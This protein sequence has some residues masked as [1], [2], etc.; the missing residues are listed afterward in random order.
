MKWAIV[1]LMTL[2]GLVHLMGPAKAFGWAELPQLAQPISR[3][4]GVAWFLAALAL[5]ATAMSFAVSLRDWWAIGLVAVVCSQ[6]VIVSSWGD[7]R[8]GTL[9]NVVL[10]LV[11]V[12]GFMSQGPPSFRAEYRAA[13]ATRLV[14]VPEMPTLTE[15]DLAPLPEPVRR[16]I[17]LTGAVGRPRAHHVRAVWAGRIRAGPDDP[18]M[19]F[20]AEQWNF[21]DEPARFFHMD[22]RRAGL[23]VDVLH[24]F[25]GG[26]ASMRVRMLSM[27]PLVDA[28][29]PELTRAETVTLLNDIALLSPSALAGPGLR[30]ESIDD[31]SAR[32]RYRLGSIE[33]TAVLH[34]NDAGELTDF[35]SDDRLA[36]SRDGSTFEARPWSTPVEAYRDVGGLHLMSRGEARWHTPEGEYAYVEMELL[37]LEVNGGR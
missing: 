29:G 10:L 24:V 12:W 1:V 27:I 26:E 11:V 34:V 23:P 9:P 2:H 6:A 4:G 14:D 18:W 7:A 13:V 25:R 37:E 17:R 5:L 33:T 20:T 30:W 31:R 28:R 21:P 36:A 22:A 15:A 35:V 3:V 19:E 8:F 32:V 16:Y